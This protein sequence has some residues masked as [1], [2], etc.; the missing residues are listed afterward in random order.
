[1]ET[2]ASTDEFDRTP[3]S[4]PA[5]QYTFDEPQSQTP[6]PNS[7]S[8]PNAP[9]PPDPRK[10]SKA[11]KVQK[12]NAGGK[13]KIEKSARVK[14][15]EKAKSLEKEELNILKHITNRLDGPPPPPPPEKPTETNRDQYSLFGEL[16][17]VK[18][19]KLSEDARIEVEIAI[20]AAIAEQQL[21]DIRRRR[22]P[23]PRS[24]SHMDMFA[25]SPQY[26]SDSSPIRPN[27]VPQRYAAQPCF[28]RMSV[29]THFNEDPADPEM[30][31]P[32]G[33]AT[34]SSTELH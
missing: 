17:A 13:Q 3:P 16:I 26:S 2:S 28:N 24:Q 23:T 7:T 10:K 27:Y 32:I 14:N 20:N 22:L 8:H 12:E 11:T 31:S 15:W 1:M 25:H 6:N 4:I 21:A 18:M 33:A 29:D 5:L 30:L 9:P 34:K 19:R